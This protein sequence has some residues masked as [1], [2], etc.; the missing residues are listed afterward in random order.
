MSEKRRNM[1]IYAPLQL[2][3]SVSLCVHF[4]TE[5]KY[6]CTYNCIVVGSSLDADSMLIS[7]ACASV[8]VD[9]RAASLPSQSPK[10]NLAL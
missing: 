2:T 7:L 5:R 1:N 3:K 8:H 10:T 6:I 4:Y 9:W